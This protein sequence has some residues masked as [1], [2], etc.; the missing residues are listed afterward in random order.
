MYLSS[1]S[2]G[3][4]RPPT[5]FDTTLE[6]NLEKGQFTPPVKNLAADA[7]AFMAA[8]TDTS[9]NTVVTALF[10]LVHGSPHRLARLKS[11]LVEG[12]PDI[13]S[14][15]GWESLEKLPYLVRTHR[16]LRLTKIRLNKPSTARS[17]QREP[18]SQLRCPWP[19]SSPCA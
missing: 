6:P 16:A 2:P 4:D 7:F 13:N 1:H 12:I 14:I 17:N 10:N 15:V 9:T 5:V 18:S 3:R 8:G 11:E 19:R